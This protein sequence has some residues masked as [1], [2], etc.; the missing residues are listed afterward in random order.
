MEKLLRQSSL[1]STLS[2]S[3][4]RCYLDP[5]PLAASQDRRLLNHAGGCL[6]GQTWQGIHPPGVRRH[7]GSR[8]LLR[9][10]SSLSEP[11]LP[12]SLSSSDDAFASW[13][14]HQT[15]TQ[16]VSWSPSLLMIKNLGT[17]MWANASIMYN[18]AKK[19]NILRKFHK[20]Y[21][22]F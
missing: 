12:T 8:V 20:I 16:R 22:G 18:M 11:I 6:S 14:G 13:N 9:V 15:A 4:L 17:F 1:L 3:I 2:T 5:L 21:P 7:A 10:P 19:N